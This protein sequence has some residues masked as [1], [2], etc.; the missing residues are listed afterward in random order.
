MKLTIISIAVAI[1]TLL[2]FNLGHAQEALSG[3]LTVNFADES[4]EYTE[5]HDF[6]AEYGTVKTSVTVEPN[7]CHYCLENY[8][9]SQCLE[10]CNAQ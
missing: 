9:P 2:S 3:I 5:S 7:F 4:A 6:S 8:N 10:A 1:I